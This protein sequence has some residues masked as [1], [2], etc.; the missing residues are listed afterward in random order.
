MKKS[1]K[2]LLILLSAS[3]VV[4]AVLQFTKR[5]G[6]SSSLRTELV[7]FDT[8]TVSKVEITTF[9]GT[10]SLEKS[11]GRWYVALDKGKKETKDNVVTSMLSA[12]QLI[13]PSRLVGRDSSKWKEYEVDSTGT[14]VKVYE[15]NEI[16]TDIMLGR[17]GVEGQRNF[18]TYVRLV[19]DK[20]IYVAGDF[21]K[22]S[23]YE[24]TE[25]YRNNRV[26][27]LDKDSLVAVEFQYPE[28]TFTM[29]K[30][31]EWQMNDTALD[32]VSVA[33]YLQ[34]LSYL[35]NRKFYDEPVGSIPTHT[36]RFSFTN[37][38]DILINGYQM[39]DDLIVKSSENTIEV[40][41]DPT[42]GEKIFVAVETLHK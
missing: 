32:S 33:A 39:G 8:A 18:H 40:F 26:I 37:Q 42:L 1:T 41:N 34:G 21:M 31:T 23:V 38:K 4:L 16:K 13:K 25:A 36:V 2:N 20:D 28:G 35:E 7:A 27:Q 15:G 14:R 12:L 10:V 6:R 19:E 9:R 3:L 5:D 29:K 22:M 24:N 17:F 30:S 11:E